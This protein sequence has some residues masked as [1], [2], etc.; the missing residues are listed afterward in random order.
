MTDDLPSTGQSAASIT[1][2]FLGKM[3]IEQSPAAKP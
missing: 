3:E 1:K 2:V